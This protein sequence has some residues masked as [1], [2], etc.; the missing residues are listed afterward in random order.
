MALLRLPPPL[1]ASFLSQQ[2]SLSSSRR[3]CRRRVDAIVAA[4]VVVIVVASAPPSSR[5][6]SP[7]PQAAPSSSHVTGRGRSQVAVAERGRIRAP[8]LAS[9]RSTG[10]GA[11]RYSWWQRRRAAGDPHSQG[12]PA[13]DPQASAPSWPAAE[14]APRPATEAATS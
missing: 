9:G 4:V 14:A 12:E 7:Y 5:V 13:A 2:F 6:S 8:G 3:R 10:V 11:I 1:Q